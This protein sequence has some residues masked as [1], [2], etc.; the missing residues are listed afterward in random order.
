MGGP[1]LDAASRT[2]KPCKWPIVYLEGSSPFGWGGLATR[3][4]TRRDIAGPPYLLTDSVASNAKAS[5]PRGRACQHRVRRAAHAG[6]AGSSDGGEFGKAADALGCAGRAPEP[7]GDV[8]GDLNLRGG[9]NPACATSCKQRQGRNSGPV[10]SLDYPAV[11]FPSPRRSES[12][13]GPL[14]TSRKDVLSAKPPPRGGKEDGQVG[15][16]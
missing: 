16:L 10:A 4:G 15:D 13:D 6:S 3:C 1:P 2:S 9:S 7:G 11:S 5:N 12:R 8:G 14:S